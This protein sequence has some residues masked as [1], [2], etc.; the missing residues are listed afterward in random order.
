MWGALSGL[1][2]GRITL[3][4]LVIVRSA[5]RCVGLSWGVYLH[6]LKRYKLPSC[7]ET[8]ADWVLFETSMRQ[9][10]VVDF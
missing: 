7:V 8:N 10:S 2:H 6:L 1:F 4:L 3:F 9:F 5:V